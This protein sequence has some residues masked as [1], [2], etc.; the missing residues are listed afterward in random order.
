[1]AG[2]ILSDLVM[3]VHFAWVLFIVLGMPVL[4]WLNLARWR[5]FHFAAL[6]V[7]VVM[8]V[9]GTIC[10]LTYLEA[11][12][13]P[14][15]TAGDVYPGQ[16]VMEFIESIMYVDS[17]A[18]KTVEVLTIVLLAATALS[19]VLRPVPLGKIMRKKRP[20]PDAATSMRPSGTGPENSP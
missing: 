14:G 17:S 3:A 2:T 6:V 1:M 8:Q 9:A 18:L 13:R 10:P 7:T 15:R 11:A 5:L 12:L 19:F 16:F 20:G 4:V